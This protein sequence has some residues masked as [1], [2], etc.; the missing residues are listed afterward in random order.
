MSKDKERLWIVEARFMD[1]LWDICNFGLKKY[2]STNYLKAHKIRKEQQKWLQ[3]HG[4]KLWTPNKFR[5]VEYIKKSQKSTKP[6]KK[7]GA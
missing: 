2:A 4:N 3:K 5:V 6:S 1:G 7:K